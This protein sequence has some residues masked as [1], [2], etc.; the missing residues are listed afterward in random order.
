MSNNNDLDAV[1]AALSAPE[2]QPSCSISVT[3]VGIPPKAEKCPA[4]TTVAEFKKANGYTG[5]KLA[6]KNADGSARIL[7]DDEV[8]TGDMSLFTATAKKNG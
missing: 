6:T 2:P 7:S 5:A 1:V 3:T 4:G 8:I